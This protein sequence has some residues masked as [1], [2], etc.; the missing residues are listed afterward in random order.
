MPTTR[1]SAFLRATAALLVV[2]TATQTLSA[3]DGTTRVA[4]SSPGIALPSAAP[5]QW[6]PR[7]AFPVPLD[8][9]VTFISSG[10]RGDFLHVIG[11]HDGSRFRNTVYQAKIAKDG[12]IGEWEDGEAL[13]TARAGMAF[14][15]DG[16]YAILAGGRTSAT[17]VTQEVY[18][19][20]VWG[21]GRLGAFK[22]TTFTMPAKRFHS[23]AVIANGFVYVI[24]G[25]DGTSATS[26]VFRA[27]ISR[28][29]ELG[30]W[31]TLDA[32]PGPRSHQAAFVQDGAIYLVAGIAGDPAGDAQPLHDVLRA[33]VNKDG[34]LGAWQVVSQL[35]AKFTTQA[36]AVHDG[37]LYVIGGVADDDKVNDRVLRAALQKDGS[38]GAWESTAAT[39]PA[40]RAQVHQVPVLRDHLYSI[41][42]SR[43]GKALDDV[44]VGKFTN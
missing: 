42:G 10:S 11:G 26:T 28:T 23:G 40:A 33:T 29:G 17:D 6:A 15:T 27:K 13:P 9:H 25:N 30:A 19:A 2:A 44:V 21:D 12:S 1:T 16:R 5:I 7:T 31:T 8:Q 41:G 36:T 14:A 20:N 39:L 22:P 24:G 18:L 32:L 37:F 34:S 4:S 38:L 43:S 35:D 3:Q